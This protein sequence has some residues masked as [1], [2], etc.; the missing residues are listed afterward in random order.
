[1]TAIVQETTARMSRLAEFLRFGVAGIVNTAFGFGA[2]SALV[3]LG[4]PVS[5]SLLVATVTGIFFNFLTFGAFAF[6][7]RDIRR[8]PRFLMAYGGMYLVNL[9]LLEAVRRAS[10]L[11]PIA[12]QFAC[13]LLVAPTTYFLLKATVFRAHDDG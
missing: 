13:L 4:M 12:A 10:A 1:M 11:G 9:A 8:L 3:L 5:V 2:Y 7:Q 6:R